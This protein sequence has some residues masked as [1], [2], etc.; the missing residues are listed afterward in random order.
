MQNLGPSRMW[1]SDLYADSNIR[2]MPRLVALG[3]VFRATLNGVIVGW[4]HCLGKGS[5]ASVAEMVS[6]PKQRPL[7]VLILRSMGRR[8]WWVH[9][10]RQW[11]KRSGQ[12]KGIQENARHTLTP[13]LPG[14]LCISGMF[15]WS[16]PADTKT[17]CRQLWDC[18]VCSETGAAETPS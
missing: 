8:I 6:S 16:L 10:Y 15:L 3:D 14:V 2:L 4:P 12:S 1:R 11:S 5:E 13:L 9:N 17:D 7:F 18:P